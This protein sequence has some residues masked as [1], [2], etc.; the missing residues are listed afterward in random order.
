MKQN[1]VFVYE[2]DKVPVNLLLT[3]IAAKEKQQANREVRKINLW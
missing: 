2:D 1:D 3:S